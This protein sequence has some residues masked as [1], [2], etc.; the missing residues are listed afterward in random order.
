M[1]PTPLPPNPKLIDRVEY[2][3]QWSVSWMIVDIKGHPMISG[4][5]TGFLMLIPIFGIGYLFSIVLAILTGHCK[6]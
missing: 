6:P 5:C 2:A 4:L 3:L 1:K